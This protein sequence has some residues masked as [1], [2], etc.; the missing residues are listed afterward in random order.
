MLN[1]IEVTVYG[2]VTDEQIKKAVEDTDYIDLYVEPDAESER[3]V[4]DPAKAHDLAE[5]LVEINGGEFTTEQ[6]QELAGRVAA[7]ATAQAP[8]IQD[9]L[10]FDD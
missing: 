7:E 10:H 4:V 3:V 5:Y 1:P 8:S 2:V 6:V 9:W